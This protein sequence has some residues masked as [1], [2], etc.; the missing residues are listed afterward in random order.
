MDLAVHD[1]QHPTAVR[2]RA[3]SHRGCVQ[4]IGRPVGLGI[5]GCAHRPR[6]HDGKIGGN[7]DVE[8][9]G[10]LLHRVGAM[11]DDQAIGGPLVHDGP[12]ASSQPQPDLR[13]HALAGDVAELLDLDLA[14]ELQAGYGRNQARPRSAQG[15]V[16]R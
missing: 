12:H 3:G 7:G 2:L 4:D 11:Q 9:E 10:R 6:E 15:Q 1:D 5:G 16:R 8:E 13:P 14:E